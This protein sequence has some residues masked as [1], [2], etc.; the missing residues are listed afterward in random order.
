VLYSDRALAATVSSGGSVDFGLAM[1]PITFFPYAM[2][3]NN[4]RS[5]PQGFVSNKRAGHVIVLKAHC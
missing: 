5:W 3:P 2:R 1:Q 4:Q